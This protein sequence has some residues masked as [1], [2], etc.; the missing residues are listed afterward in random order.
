MITDSL[1]RFASH[2]Q[3]NWAGREISITKTTSMPAIEIQ[4]N[5]VRVLPWQKMIRPIREKHPQNSSFLVLAGKNAGNSSPEHDAKL[6]NL[7]VHVDAHTVFDMRD[8]RLVLLSDKEVIQFKV[9]EPL[10]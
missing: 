8:T 9:K 6:R 4:L 2:M 10:Q 5:E 7:V 1:D 3:N